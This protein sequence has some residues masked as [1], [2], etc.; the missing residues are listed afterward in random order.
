MK[1]GTVTIDIGAHRLVITI[2][3]GRRYFSCAFPEIAERFDGTEDPLPAIET[4][5]RLAM[6][7]PAP[8]PVARQPS[9]FDDIP[10]APAQSHSPTSRA[11]AK[12]IEPLAGELRRRVYE[13]LVSRG[14][15]GS[16]D[17]ELIDALGLA[18]S[19]ARPRRIELVAAGLARDSGRTRLTKARRKATVWVAVAANNEEAA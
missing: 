17:E 15:E 1:T 9:L 13:W 16:T 18:S 3:G 10:D 4:F 2:A 8:A 5:E 19:T 12:A 6:L 11:A 14:E 7:P